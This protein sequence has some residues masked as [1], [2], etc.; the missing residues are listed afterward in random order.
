MALRRIQKAYD[1]I[2]LQRI[3][4][5]VQELADLA[6]DPP[7]GCSAGPVTDDLFYWEGTLVGPVPIIFRLI[8]RSFDVGLESVC[9]RYFPSCDSFA[10]GLSIS[11]AECVSASLCFLISKIRSDF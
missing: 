10:D 7:V 8:N 4:F 5:V 11:P 9:G 1:R 6:R 3:T 2:V